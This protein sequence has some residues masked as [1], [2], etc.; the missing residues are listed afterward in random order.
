MVRPCLLH[1]GVPVVI[2]LVC[3]DELI[4][5]AVENALDFRSARQVFGDQAFAGKRLDV[6]LFAL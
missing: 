4:I 2:R 5:E 6:L 1:T 3:M